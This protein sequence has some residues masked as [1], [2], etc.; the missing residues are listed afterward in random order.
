MV[1]QH[2]EDIFG[3]LMIEHSIV[4]ENF[5][6]KFDSDVVKK[7]NKES[8]YQSLLNQNDEIH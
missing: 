6:H 1:N 2:F 4:E 8:P 7:E 5:K 3:K